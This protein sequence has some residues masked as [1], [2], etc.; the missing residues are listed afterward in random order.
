VIAGRSRWRQEG[1]VSRFHANAIVENAGY[2]VL[3]ERFEDRLNRPE[4]L[5]Y[6]VGNHQDVPSAEIG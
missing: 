4:I 2:T 1:L 3:F 6:G 5:Q